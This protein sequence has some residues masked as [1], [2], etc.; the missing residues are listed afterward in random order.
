MAF[1]GLGLGGKVGVRRM[2]GKIEEEEKYMN[3]RFEKEL[4]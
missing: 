4:Q 3:K 1:K 2:K